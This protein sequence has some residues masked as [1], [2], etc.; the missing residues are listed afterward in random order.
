MNRNEFTVTIAEAAKQLE[1]ICK[2]YFEKKPDGSSYIPVNRQR[3]IML[4]GPAGIGKTDIP[5]RTAEKLGIGFISYSIT[6]HTRQSLIGLPKIIEK[7]YG[8]DNMLTTEYTASEIIAA[9]YRAIDE[10][11]ND[12]GI[13]FIDEVNCVSETLAAPLLQLFQNKTFGQRKIPD[14]WI[15]VM[16]GNPPE[17]NKSVKEFDAVTRDRLRVINVVPDADAWLEYAQEKELNGAVVSYIDCERNNLYVFNSQ[18]GEIVTPRGWE[19]LSINIDAY[20]RNGI[21]ITEPFVAQFINASE[22]A[23]DFYRYY[24]L[25]NEAIG[26]K[27]IDEILDG[28][29]SQEKIKQITSFKKELQS[30][31]TI[32]L[33]RRLH[34]ASAE[35]DINAACKKLDNIVSFI[36][37]AYGKGSEIEMFMSNVLNDTEIVK[38]ATKT[39]NKEFTDFLRYITG[40]KKELLKQVNNAGI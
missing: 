10:D 29:I 18:N 33:K 4:I 21:D 31:L 6:H 26:N 1:D 32:L 25:I 40:A 11:G 16:A 37:K 2:T 35:D 19:E 7:T 20:V 30:Y 15:L 5:R 3:P 17:Y 28:T 22:T 9:V 24:S 8:G 27:E 38:M 23:L 34:A 36:K 13:L 14:G 12:K 39:G